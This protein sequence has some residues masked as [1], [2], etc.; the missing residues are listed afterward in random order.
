M[1]GGEGVDKQDHDLAAAD[2]EPSRADLE[3]AAQRRHLGD[4]RE[5]RV[6]LARTIGALRNAPPAPLPNC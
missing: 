4:A 6:A 3:F 1:G 5:L 2:Q